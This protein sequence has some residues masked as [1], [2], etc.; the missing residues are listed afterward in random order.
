V[1]PLRV[2]IAGASGFVGSLLVEHILKTTD[3]QVVALTRR[4]RDKTQT[5]PRLEW[6][7]CDLFSMLELEAAMQGADVA[8]YLVHSMLPSARLTQGTFLDFDLMLADNFARS[9]KKSGVRQIIYLS[10]IIPPDSL[11]SLHLKSR[12]EVETIFRASGIATT[13]MRAG[14]IIGPSGSSFEIMRRLVK[15]LAVMVCPS[16]TATISCPVSVWDVISLITSAINCP[17]AFDKTYDV[18]GPDPLSYREMMQSLAEVMQVKRRFIEVPFVSPTISRLWVCTITGAPKN[19]VYPLID[20]LKTNM[21]AY[22]NDEIDFADWSP[23][24]FTEAL[25]KSIAEAEHCAPNAFRYTGRINKTNRVRSVQRMVTLFKS[26]VEKIAEMYFEW[27]SV[28]LSFIFSIRFETK[29]IIHIHLK[30]LS[31][32]LLTFRYSSSRSNNGRVLY[33]LSDG[34]LV[35]P[36]KK[37]RLEFRDIYGG[38]YKIIAIH[39]YEP[40]LP[41]FIYKYTQAIVHL[42]VMRAFSRYLFKRKA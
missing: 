31:R 22:G 13:C 7:S 6:L 30:L 8:I 32:P 9:A 29:E 5:T 15:R 16:W 39:E 17:K 35:K 11:L 20:S 28:F 34:L 19:L 3:H 25:K 24:S 40:R 12:L 18:V 26:P 2:V 10:G 27:L 36:N 1:K 37:G 23:M 41:W 14:V 33:Y 4:E 21:V 42:F 38:L